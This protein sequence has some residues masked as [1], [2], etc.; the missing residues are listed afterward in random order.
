MTE[1]RVATALERIER[2][3]DRIDLAADAGRSA[4]AELDSLKERHAALRSRIEGAIVEIDQMLE[5]PEAG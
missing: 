1:E 5:A 4:R 2:A 3:L